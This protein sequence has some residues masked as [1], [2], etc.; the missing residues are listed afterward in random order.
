MKRRPAA[1]NY[2]KRK[3]INRGSKKII[4]RVVTAASIFIVSFIFLGVLSTYK[5]LNESFASAQTYKY[6]SSD[7]ISDQFPTLVYAVVDDL[8][9]DPRFITGLKYLVFDKVNKKVVVF[10]VP[11]ELKFDMPGKYGVEGLSKALAL[12]GLNSENPLEDGAGLLK[13]TILKIFGFK[14]DRFLIVSQRQ[15]YL[16][17]EL[18]GNGSFLDLI[19]IKDVLSV[20]DDF[21]TDLKLEEFYSLFTFVK[22]LPNDRL[23]Q[24]TITEQDLAAT[25]II[26]ETL[27][28]IGGNSY[29][30][31]ESK[32]VSILNSTDIPGTASFGARV[33]NNIGG[34]VVASGNSDKTYSSSV[35]VADDPNS[36]TCRFLSSV[37][38][39]TNI[40]P[41]GGNNLGEHEI[42]RSDIVVIIGFDTSSKL[43]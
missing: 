14:T 21:I 37:F 36:Q 32:S 6:D 17:D 30:A 29:I 26:D 25:D 11:V 33:V 35:I 31:S 5:Y 40:V 4:H 24:K 20:K 42:D 10:T 15:S 2:K 39:I 16:F 13:N 34:R 27:S 7:Y 43:Y 1:K 23:V 12:A 41:K 9:K 22:S 28:D 18:L 38:K 3:V 8:N 19:K